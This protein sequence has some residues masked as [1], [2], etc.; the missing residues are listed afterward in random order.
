[1][2]IIQVSIAYLFFRIERMAKF[3]HSDTSEAKIQNWP[4][5]RYLLFYFNHVKHG[6]T[7][8]FL[9]KQQGILGNSIQYEILT[10]LANHFRCLSILKETEIHLF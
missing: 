8:E 9:R 1:M 7:E 2:Q 6:S 3:R 10:K 4:I 5:L